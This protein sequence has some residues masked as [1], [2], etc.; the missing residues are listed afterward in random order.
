MKAKLLCCSLLLAA[1]LPGGCKKESPDNIPC[2][3]NGWIP[4]S[5]RYSNT[6][7]P[8]LA[9]NCIG[10][11]NNNEQQGNVNLSGYENVKQYASNDLLLGSMAHL[12]R[13]KPMPKNADKLPQETICKVKYWIDNGA[14]NN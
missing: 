9:Q 5:V 11:H 2:D 4:D 8:I 10:C 14:L 6:V 3:T 12:K 13:Y 7:A 1:I